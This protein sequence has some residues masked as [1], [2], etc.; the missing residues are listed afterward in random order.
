MIYRL[1]GLGA[2][3]PRDW[4]SPY[5]GDALLVSSSMVNQLPVLTPDA[6]ARNQVLMASEVASLVST[7]EETDFYRK[8][9][10]IW[11]AIAV[12]VALFLLGGRR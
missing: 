7:P 12:A 2:D 4:G 6:Y 3:D 9:F 10:W 1:Q 5:G 8:R 11:I